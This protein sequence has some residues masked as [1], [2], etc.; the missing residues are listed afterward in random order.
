M[1]IPSSTSYA[2]GEQ[3]KITVLATSDMHGRIYPWDYAIDSATDNT[4]FA[5]AY[6]VV[7]EVRAENPNTILIDNGDTIQDNMASLFNN[8]EIHPMIQAMN[9]MDYDAWTLGN[10]EFNFGLDVLGRAIK[11]SEAPILAANIYKADGTRF[12]NPY[13]IKEIQGVKVAIVGMITHHIPRWEA[14]TPK[15]FEGLTFVDPAEETKKVLAELDGKADVI[16]GSYHLGEEGEYGAVGLAEIAKAHPQFTAMIAGHAHSD[17]PGKDVNGVLLVEPKNNGNK[18]SR[19]DLTLEQKDGKW[20]VVDKASKN[21][22]TKTYPSDVEMEAAFKAYHDKAREEVNVVIGKVTANFLDQVDVLPG[23]PTAQVQDTALVDFINEVQ[24]H[25]TG[26]DISAA[27]LFDSKSNVLAG[28]F[29]KKDVANIYKYEN[30]LMAVK[31]NGK[32]L[33]EYMEAYA[34][35]YFNTYKPGDVTISFDPNIRGYNFDMFAG[36]DYQIDI[37]KPVGE[38]IVNLT[39]K[40]KPVTDEIEFTLALNNYRFG[41]LSKD[42]IIKESNKVYDSYEKFGDDGRV[43]DLIVKYVQEKETIM[44][45]TDNNWK[46]IGA[47]LNH[48]LKDKVYE[49]VKK[50]ELKIPTSEDGRT[51]NVKA[52]NVNDLIKEGKLAADSGSK[53]VPVSITKAPIVPAANVTYTVKAGDMLW[54]IAKQFGIDLKKLAEF[55]QLKNANM[56]FPGQVLSIPQP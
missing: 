30:T 10:H 51:P 5:K 27:A 48:P 32:E 6:S 1:A 41:G 25:Y 38:R 8:E 22:D 11:G 16:I 46:I 54:K 12:V 2:A 21:I 44:P 55:N 37:S 23:I 9:M 45:T 33:K 26:A 53:P 29:K 31:V 56:I 18:V 43:R 36:V 24:M 15:N 52:L 50:G 7:K 19:I 20:I 39:F 3:V 47:D 28:D 34:G 49:M 4:G 17:I 40:G 35:K 42:G 13:M 14:S